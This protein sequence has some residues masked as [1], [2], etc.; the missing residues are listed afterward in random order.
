M[1]KKV[2]RKTR[3]RKLSNYNLI[4]IHIVSPTL[5]KKARVKKKNGMGKRARQSY[6][7]N[8]IRKKWK[9]PLRDDP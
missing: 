6:I 9:T 5:G 7:L 8:T 3:F 4:N 1:V 2:K